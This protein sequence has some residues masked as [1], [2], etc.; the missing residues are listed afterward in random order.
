MKETM[1]LKKWSFV[2]KK[3]QRRSLQR[4]WCGTVRGEAVTA[5]T[6]EKVWDRE[7]EQEEAGDWDDC[8]V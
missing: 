7:R 6:R 3:D 8:E 1:R 4:Q 2:R 5:E